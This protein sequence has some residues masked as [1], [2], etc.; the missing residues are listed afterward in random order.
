MVAGI[1][2][3]ASALALAACGSSPAAP[4]T[5]KLREVDVKGFGD[6]LAGPKGFTLYT[7]SLDRPNRSECTGSCLSGW[8]P[9]TVPRSAKL[10]LPSGVAGTAATI[11]RSGGATQ[12]VFD[13]RP[14]YYFGYDTA[15][16]DVS[17][18]ATNNQWYAVQLP[19][20][21]S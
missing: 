20:T 16:G 9:F 1:L 6:V 13:G 15:T 4:T 7:F 12:V 3:A 19:S 11:V 8:P 21:S 10:L 2:V 18:Q 17:G 5:V 14:L